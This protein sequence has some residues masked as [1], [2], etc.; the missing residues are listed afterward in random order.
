MS[1][2]T[3]YTFEAMQSE[4]TA[5]RTFV[6]SVKGAVEQFVSLDSHH[7]AQRGCERIVALIAEYEKERAS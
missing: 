5:L 6:A 2:R 3:N 7:N 1:K 4:L